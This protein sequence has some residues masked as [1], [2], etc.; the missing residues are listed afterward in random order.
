[1]LGLR[2]L[3]CTY[4]SRIV[5]KQILSVSGTQIMPTVLTVFGFRFQFVSF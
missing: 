3:N 4:K 2:V 1:M 5:Y